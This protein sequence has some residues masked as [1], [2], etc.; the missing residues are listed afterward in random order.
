MSEKVIK[1]SEEK[2]ENRNRLVGGF[3]LIILGLLALAAQFVDLEW[4]GLLILPA[5][6]VIFFVWG[7]LTRQSGL[8]IPA[9]ILTGLGIGTLLVAGPFEGV[10]E[11]TQGGIFM[12]AFAFGWALIPLFS[13]L[14]TR[15]RHLWALIPGGIMAL[16]G[17]GLL[18]GGMAFTI[19]EFLGIV[20]PV[21]L[22]LG[23]LYLIFRRSAGRLG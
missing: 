21:F 11:D 20:W 6:G 4:L 18:F 8:F 2:V 3:A 12:L 22:I 15:E 17:I 1:M 19:L 5:L 16:I 14:F 23:G 9:G 10:T 13:I 7:L